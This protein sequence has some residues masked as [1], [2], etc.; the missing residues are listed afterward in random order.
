MTDVTVVF[1]DLTGSTGIFES[2]GNLKATRAITNVTQWIGKVCTNHG[3]RVVKYL[4]DGVL[5][6]FKDNAK[7]VGAVIEMQRLHQQRI[8]EWPQPLRMGLQIGMARGEIVEQAGDCFGDAV[9]LASRLSDLSG[10]EQIFA[11]SAVIDQ[12]ERSRAAGTIRS[13]CL[14]ELDIRGRTEA[15]VVH[16]IEWQSEVLSDLMTVRA[17][18]GE[19]TPDTRE[20]GAL[21]EIELSWLGTHTAFSQNQLPAFLGRDANAQFI[22]KDQ[23]VSRPKKA[24]SWFCQHRI[25]GRQVLPRRCEQLRHLGTVF[26]HQGGGG[27]AAAGMCV[28]GRRRNRA[29]R[30]VRRLHRTYR[31][32]QAPDRRHLHLSPYRALFQRIPELTI[33]C[34]RRGKRLRAG[35][36]LVRPGWRRH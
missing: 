2:L 1:A 15:C 21:P 3:G 33:F 32:L 18:F 7:A 6:V 8:G 29:G 20:F 13:V 10:P 35:T 5:V 23:R 24:G 30:T 17:A 36:S 19:S 28:D 9:N 22:V 12:L 26:R 14:G 16:K 11:T 34:P 31:E 4:G 25:P 27:L